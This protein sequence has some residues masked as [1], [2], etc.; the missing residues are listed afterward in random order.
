[1]TEGS[2]TELWRQA[3]AI[4]DQLLDLHESER[5]ERLAQLAPPGVLRQRVEQLL[6]ALDQPGILDRQHFTGLDALA[7]TPL[8]DL[9]G[10]TFGAYSLESLIGRGGMSAV[11]LAHRVDGAYDAPVAL[12]LLNPGLL[13]TDWHQRFR[14][15]AGFLASLRH[16]HIASL[17][18]AG[19]ADD[20]TP[21]LV[22]EFVDGEPIDHYSRRR[23]LGLRARVALIRDLCE[24]VAFAQRNLVVHRDI[25]PE[26]VLVTE[27][28]RVVLL[29]F[30][31]ARAL[32]PD[33]GTQANNQSTRA[34]TPEYAAPEQL[35]GQAVTTATDVFSL[36]VVLYRLLTD[37]AP[38]V[39]C[40][41]TER[42][43]S[44]VRPSRQVA[45]ADGLDAGE[46][47]RRVQVL[48]GDLDNVVMKAL[49]DEP[50][51]RYQNAEQLRSDLAAWLAFR[52]VSARA[53]STA[54]RLALFFRRRT[55]LAVSLLALALVATSGLAATLWQAREA[56]LQA[57]VARSVSDYLVTVFTTS[58]PTQDE[59]EDP[60]ASELLRRGS[61]QALDKLGSE[62]AVAA[63]LL[64]VIGSIQRKLGFFEDAEISLEAALERM[65]NRASNA[66]SRAEAMMAY[67]MLAHDTGHYELSVERQLQALEALP[68]SIGSRHPRRLEGHVDLAQ[69]LVWADPPRAL[70]ELARLRGMVDDAELD[71]RLRIKAMRTLSMVLDE[72]GLHP[73]E[74]AAV[75]DKALV[76][77]ERGSGFGRLEI[78]DIHGEIA[79]MH[80]MRG[81]Y[82]LASDSLTGVLAIEEEIFGSDHPRLV[83]ILINLGFVHFYAGQPIQSLQSFD[84]G[85]AIGSSVWEADHEYLIELEA[86]SAGPLRA[87]GDFQR[88]HAVVAGLG[89]VDMAAG[90]FTFLQI[91]GL[92]GHLEQGDWQAAVD[93]GNRL[94]SDA[95]FDQLSESQ[96][97][98]LKSL[99]ACALAQQAQLDL[100]QALVSEVSIPDQT[101][102]RWALQL[103]ALAMIHLMG[104]LDQPQLLADWRGY[105]DQADSIT[106][107]LASIGLFQ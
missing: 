61:V 97:G 82:A 1:M 100:A 73:E 84:R 87:L 5:S 106:P 7:D 94:F 95:R 12:K 8:P 42:R 48:K 41:S 64:R 6:K 72:N 62:P 74:V 70:D 96:Q 83:S 86:A 79:L 16:P 36:G 43:R 85:Y 22:T 28:G 107:E 17:L 44:T 45:T 65:P 47:R 25:K 29:D 76:L 58:D 66:L 14:R 46:R 37:E 38:F 92:L 27:Q 54:Y 67:A 88:L 89:G 78:S 30:G 55:A 69:L 26:N 11:Y 68:A 39:P 99:V 23:K 75:L 80:M 40:G 51:R 34:F 71:D 9:S 2:T 13:A 52:P 3:D 21:W 102:S 20:G 90:Y 19:V 93:A 31:I 105:L 103:Q 91:N 49:A 33:A 60:P 18:D 98:V 24:A 81:D 57:E 35:A 53:P 104:I 32:D 63:E 77:A 15:E 10:R 50:E 59:A 101:P 56:R 4:L